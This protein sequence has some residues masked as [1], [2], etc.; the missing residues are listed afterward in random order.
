MTMVVLSK[1]GLASGHTPMTISSFDEGTSLVTKLVPSTNSE[2][3][4]SLWTL[5]NIS[6]LS[7]I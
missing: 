5:Y 7:H 1:G 6:G 2:S 3:G 4:S